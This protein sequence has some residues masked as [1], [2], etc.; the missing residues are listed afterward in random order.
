MARRCLR[1]NSRSSA[2]PRLRAITTA[3]SGSGTRCHRPRQVAQQ[4]VGK[5]VEIGQPLAQIRIDHLGHA[6]PGV[7]LHLQH[8]TLGGEAAGDGLVQP[9]EPAPVLGEHAIGFQ[10]VEMLA[11]AVQLGALQQIVQGPVQV[12]ETAEAGARAR[13]PDS[14]PRSRP[15]SGAACAARRA[16][17]RGRGRGSAPP[18]GSAAGRCLPSAGSRCAARDRRRRSARPPPWR[19]SRAPRPPPR[20]IGARVRFC[21]T[22]TPITRPPRR[23]GTPISEW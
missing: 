4:P 9:G 14:R 17:W 10:D 22:S 11:G 21:T 1:S 16:R 12:C 13:A 23:I 2:G 7:V 5:L 3:F 18:A 15:E 6:R 8:G 19:W 20:C